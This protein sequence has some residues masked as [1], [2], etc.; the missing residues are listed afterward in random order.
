MG[1]RGL[2]AAFE[3]RATALVGATDRSGSLGS[4]LL[5]NLSESFDG[6]LYLVGPRAQALSAERGFARAT[7]LPEA[8]DLA[9]VA[10]PPDALAGALADLS[11]RGCKCAVVI[12]DARRPGGVDE[13]ALRA[14]AGRMRLIGPCSLGVAS[15]WAGLQAT[16]S[17]I[18]PEAGGLAF[19]GQNA[20]AVGPVVDWASAHGIGFSHILSLGDMIDVDFADALDLFASSRRVSAVVVYLERLAHAR[21]FLSAARALARTRPVI[22]MKSA[23]TSQALARDAVFDAAF[24]R[25]GMVRV[26]TLDDLFDAL[27]ALLVRLPADA[28]P[29]ALG[30]RL[31]IVSNGAAMAALAADSVRQ[32]GVRIAELAPQTDAALAEVSAFGRLVG[33]PVDIGTD[34]DP[35]RY[36]TALD[37]LMADPNVDAVL[38]LNGPTGVATGAEAAR[39]VVEAVAARRATRGARKPWVF[40]SWP[41]GAHEREA[42]EVFDDARVP[43]FATPSDAVRAYGLLVRHRRT[44]EALMQTPE[45]RA[46]THGVD[47][48]Q[49]RG[50]IDAA[51]A[52]GRG[53]LDAAGVDKLLAAYNIRRGD[54]SMLRESAALIRVSA[55]VDPDFGPVLRLKLG[56]AAGRRIDPGVAALPPLNLTLAAQTV[57]EGLAGRLLRQIE[58]AEDAA[59]VLLVQASEIL[60]DLVDVAGFDLDPIVVRA[61]GAYVVDARVRVRRSAARDPAARLAIRPYPVELERA[62]TDAEGKRYLLRPILPEDEPAI[63][64]LIER[65]DP[66]HLRLRFFQ[67][68]KQVSHDFAA[69]LTQIDYDREMALVLAEEGALPGAAEI[70]GAAR[71]VRE[72]EG[73]AAEYAVTVD[74]AL[75][76]RGL[77]RLLMQ[78]IIGYARDIGLE[79]VIG[80]VLA[81]NRAMLALDRKLG[82]TVARDPDDPA[83]VRATLEL[84]DA[85]AN[86]ETRV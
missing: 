40:A 56:D 42:G 83:I 18:R 13:A 73:A 52:E 32:A 77:G 78:A 84:R 49:A 16:M 67:P 59:E 9:V 44:A 53:N 36:Q 76:G 48:N 7:D 38:T 70:Y 41:G 15:P 5:A 82:F 61:D 79:R 10:T 81:E 69:R 26:R 29:T 57:R 1:M 55:H 47:R 60:T 35:A 74:S 63:V 3:P 71:L 75:Q 20:T 72:R 33:N 50:L 2:A 80:M 58:G 27:E 21:A 39:A 30:D 64:R 54:K 19:V 11:A 43:H 6:P 86:A 85:P 22:V 31:A 17:R 24:Q 8:P 34:A 28:R 37:A 25:A 12:T 62:V 51:L 23:E 45:S 65:L 46:E 68:I 66:E 4:V 14:A